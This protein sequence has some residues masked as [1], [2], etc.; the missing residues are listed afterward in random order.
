VIRPNYDQYIWAACVIL[1]AIPTLWYKIQRLR[2][3]DPAKRA[4]YVAARE[5]FDFHKQIIHKRQ[6]IILT[7]L[8]V[9]FYTYW[10]Y[11]IHAFIHHQ[12]NI[13]G[14]S[15]HAFSQGQVSA[16]AFAILSLIPALVPML[17]MMFDKDQAKHSKSPK[18]ETVP[19]T[20]TQ[21]FTPDPPSHNNNTHTTNNTNNHTHHQSITS[22]DSA[23]QTYSPYTPYTPA[24]GAPLLPSHGQ[25]DSYFG[26]GT[27]G[28]PPSTNQGRTSS[29]DPY[30]NH[31]A[32]SS[33]SYVYQPGA[34]P[35]FTAGPTSHS[36]TTPWQNP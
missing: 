6:A 34:G 36:Y 24:S 12:K 5:G 21:P 26:Q 28:R 16:I 31:L 18:A 15:E 14:D 2:I 33:T 23:Y 29:D 10:I 9:P 13:L 8:S 3:R 19:L 25:N 7:L 17:E 1:I 22:Q 35:N 32:S 11:S 30:G 27:S 20:S 4:K